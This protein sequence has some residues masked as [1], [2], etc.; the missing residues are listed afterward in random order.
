MKK[1]V[2]YVSHED[3]QVS[4]FRKRPKLALEYLNAAFELAFKENDPELVLTAMAAVA[5]AHGMS[6]VAKDAHLPRESL[7]RMLSK[8]G[9]PEWNS[10]FRVMKALHAL[11]RFRNLGRPASSPR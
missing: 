2:P 8:R 1:R 11:P 6:R 4:E 9:N 10:M 5:K 3:E 7:H